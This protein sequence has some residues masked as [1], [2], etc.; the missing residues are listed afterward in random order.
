VPGVGVAGDDEGM[1]NGPGAQE[2]VDDLEPGEHAARPVGHVE[3]EGAVAAGV[4][5]LGV[6]ADVL[7]DQGRQRGFTEV[8]VVVEAGVDEQVD[9]GRRH[10][11]ALERAVGGR[12]RQ[13]VC[14]APAAAPT[15]DDPDRLN[16]RCHCRPPVPRR[17]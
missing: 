1:P 2:A 13:H 14:G 9:V 16:D 5:V 11:G 8:A 10:P 12:I 4:R 3:R 15:R 7:L 6:G 17:R